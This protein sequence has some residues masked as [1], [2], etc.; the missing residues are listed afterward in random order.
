[1]G[2]LA[3]HNFNGAVIAVTHGLVA[4]SGLR[5]LLLLDARTGRDRWRYSGAE[6]ASNSIPAINRGFLLLTSTTSGLAGNVLLLD[7]ATLHMTRLPP[8]R[9][10]M[11]VAH[12]NLYPSTPQ[13]TAVQAIAR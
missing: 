6:L 11:A 13:A 12:R 8:A 3:H 2:P 1:M 5:T 9:A 10:V 7:P 4:L